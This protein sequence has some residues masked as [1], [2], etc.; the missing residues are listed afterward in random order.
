YKAHKAK[1]FPRADN[2]N[3]AQNEAF[4]LSDPQTRKTYER[5]YDETSAL[6]YG[7]K[8]T[9]DQILKEIAVWADRL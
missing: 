5:A 8:P 3:I 9:F 6:Y 4:I 1:R 2:Q 7:G